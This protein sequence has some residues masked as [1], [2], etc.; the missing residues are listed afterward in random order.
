MIRLTTPML[1]LSLLAAPAMAQEAMKPGAEQARIGFFAGT[2]R[3]EGEAKET[4]MG[5]GGKIGGTETC[6]WFAGG[7]HLVCQG[8]MTG[9]R[10]PA[11]TGSVWAYDPAQQAYT[12][13][14]YTSFGEA[15][16]V[17]GSAAGKVWTWNADMPAPG[18]SPVKV[19][20]TITEQSPT[21][22]QYKFEM[23]ADGTNWMV[24]EEGRAT[25]QGR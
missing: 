11:K 15:F 17:K 8:D 7:F 24:G 21:A 12:Y 4:P 18:G 9:P 13:Y 14:G 19:R 5:P 2:W 25:K 1:G 23:S 20:V 6:S 3:M 22:Y 16:Y 10:G